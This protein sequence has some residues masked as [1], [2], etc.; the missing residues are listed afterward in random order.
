[1]LLSPPNGDTRTA[2]VTG[3]GG[4]VGGGFDG[5]GGQALTFSQSVIAGLLNVHVV[6]GFGGGVLTPTL[7]GP[8]GALATCSKVAQ[9]ISL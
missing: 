4:C 9:I 7:H 8:F 3:N 5:S 2:C 1:M 6:Y